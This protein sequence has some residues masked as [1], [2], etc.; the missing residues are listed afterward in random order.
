MPESSVRQYTNQPSFQQ[1][2]IVIATLN[3]WPKNLAPAFQTTRD[4][5][6][7]NRPCTRDFSR[8]WGELQVTARN[9][10][11]FIALFAR[12]VIVRSN[13]FG[14]GCSTVI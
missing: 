14:I 13:Y 10:D 5:I 8:G 7:A 4:K 12:V 3:D 6:K 11:W 9:S 2:G 1:S